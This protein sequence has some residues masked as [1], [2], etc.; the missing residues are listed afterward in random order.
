MNFD[1]D[2]GVELSVGVFHRR[3]ITGNAERLCG[4]NRKLGGQW[5][6]SRSCVGVTDPVICTFK[7][8]KQLARSLTAVDFEKSFGCI[9]GSRLDLSDQWRKPTASE[10][11]DDH[12]G[13]SK[14]RRGNWLDTVHA[15]FCKFVC[16]VSGINPLK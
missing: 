14:Y 7:T 1:T 5:T 12:D 13:E 15:I 6:A 3:K 10:P 11:R 16:W 9:V 8:Y 4:R 2:C